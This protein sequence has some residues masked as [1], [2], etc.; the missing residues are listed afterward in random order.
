MQQGLAAGYYQADSDQGIHLAKLA[1]E[2]YIY[3]YTHNYC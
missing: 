2:I 1:S 3:D